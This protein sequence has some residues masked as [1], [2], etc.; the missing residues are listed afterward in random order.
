EPQRLQVLRADDA[1]TLVRGPHPDAVGLPRRPPRA[2]PPAQR[3]T[4]RLVRVPARCRPT[5]HADPFPCA[6]RRAVG[7]ILPNLPGPGA[8][9]R[10]VRGR[11]GIHSRS[12]AVAT[13]RSCEPRRAPSVVATRLPGRT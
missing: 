1:G 12:H 10:V 3:G 6:A 13:L 8:A 4:P 11:R 2:V 7:A 9:V 5:V